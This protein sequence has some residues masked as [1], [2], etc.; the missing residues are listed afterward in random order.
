MNAPDI[1][2]VLLMIAWLLPLLGFAI[3]VF[4]GYWQSGRQSRTAAKMAVGCIATGF[5]VS[6]AAFVVWGNHTGWQ[7]FAST[8]HDEHHAEHADEHTHGDGEDHANHNHA[9]E[10]E[11]TEPSPAVAEKPD[12]VAHTYA[13]PHQPISG[14]MYTLAKFGSLNLSM[15]YYIDSLTILMFMMVTL[16]ATCIHV[17]A[18]GYMSDELTDDY[19]DHHAHTRDGK[20]VHRPGRF[21]RFF[22]YLS[23]FCFSMLGIV[24]A[25]NIFQVFVFWE[26][27]GISSYLLIGFYVERKTAN[28]AAN[29]AFIM[30][31]VG[32]FGFLIGLM[33]VWTYFGTFS[34]GG[35]QDAES[36]EKSPGVF[37]MVRDADG[38]LT[39]E[40]QE[41]GTSVVVLHD[42]TDSGQE[43]HRTIPYWLL[44]V[45]GLGVFGGCVGKSAQFPLQTWLPDAMEGPTPVSAL[46]HSAT[47][48]AAGVYLAGRFYPMFTAE[49]LLVIAYVGCITLFLAATIAIVA[50]DIKRVLAYSTISQLGY[51]ML[52]IGVA[53]WGAGLFHLIT[54]AFFKSLMFLCSGSVIVACHHEQEMTEMGGLRK[55][56][57][58]TA[59]AMLV[60]VIAIAGLA[61]PPDLFTVAGNPISF[62][63]FHSKDAI[64]AT[65][66]AHTQLNPVHFLLFLV[67]L[68]TAGITAFYMFRLWFMTFAGKP[69]NQHVYDHAH[70]NPWVMAG[71]LVVLAVFA[72]F[73]AV[74]GESGPLY[75]MIASSEPAGVHAGLEN[76]GRF[77]Q[78]N[79]PGHGIIHDVHAQAGRYALISAVA[80]AVLAYLLYGWGIVNP[81]EIKRQ[82]AGLHHFLVEKWQFDRLYDVLF[83]RPVHVIAAGIAWIDRT[84]IDGIIHGFAKVAVAVSR[85]D[86]WFDEKAIDGLVNVVGDTTYSVGRSL[87]HV[88]T[89]RMR[90]Y[91]MFIAVGVLALFVLM[92]AMYPA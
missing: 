38:G 42:G 44:V 4:G 56:M 81:A 48:V 88:Q 66:L 64:V 27:V 30:N 58:I 14:V 65:S 85:W 43:E 2:Y 57:P 3:E 54:H 22:S 78:M 76:A 11:H 19:V 26:L 62:S 91:V 8:G 20:H 40:K 1:I 18:I 7:A 67:P 37:A 87:S 89:G 79:L 60:G 72:A 61:I 50:T 63:G 69:R 55:K 28:V 92:F 51:M 84:I 17:F 10:E 49:V 90:Q 41:D 71:P 35:L 77:G 70:E 16:I 5:V 32:D 53:G 52:A 34:F 6:V 86:R 25:G 13:D 68:V 73:C 33:V 59:Y 75:Q 21:Y 80:G 36:D 12:A 9:D 83:V 82:L 24:I 46:V 31:R 15:E 47:M 29:K 45:V 39:V 23:L 74:G